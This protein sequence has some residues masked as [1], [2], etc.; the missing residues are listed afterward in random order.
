LTIVAE[1]T[2]LPDSACET[3]LPET[4]PIIRPRQAPA[5]PVE[6]ERALVYIEIDADIDT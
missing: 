2:L 4:T 6:R 5:L 1:N 3:G